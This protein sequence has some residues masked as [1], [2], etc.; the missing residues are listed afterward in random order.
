MTVD[1]A[2]ERKLSRLRGNLERQNLAINVT[3]SEIDEV[4]RNPDKPRYASVLS[5]L[6]TKL[7]RQQENR[8]DTAA[9]IEAF[10]YPSKDPMQIEA[11]ELLEVATTAEGAPTKVEPPPNP[12]TPKHRTR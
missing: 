10:E 4:K 11:R 3:I 2:K 8:D 12:P 7:H 1:V 5:K 9:L 6:T